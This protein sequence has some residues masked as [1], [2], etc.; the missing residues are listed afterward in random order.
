MP[1]VV[2]DYVKHYQG[3]SLQQ[4]T[5]NIMAWN[6][7]FRVAFKLPQLD[8]I[9]LGKMWSSE[10]CHFVDQVDS[11]QFAISPGEITS[12]YTR[13]QSVD[14]CISNTRKKCATIIHIWMSNLKRA[15]ASAWDTQK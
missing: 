1:A 5:G 4:H 14:K 11:T 2:F 8:V 9:D 12:N 7:N 3:L 15:W 13:Y 10:V 6:M